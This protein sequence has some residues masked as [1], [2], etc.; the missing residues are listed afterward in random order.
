MDR[1]IVLWV[2]AI[3]SIL[4]FLVTVATIYFG[5]QTTQLQSKVSPCVGSAQV[6]ESKACQEYRADIARSGD[7]RVAC[8]NYE[9]ATGRE[10]GRCLNVNTGVSIP[11]SRAEVQAASHELQHQGGGS[12]QTSVPSSPQQPGPPQGGSDGSTGETGGSGGEQ[13]PD[14]TP[15][16]GPPP[17]A[18]EPP[19][20]I[21]NVDPAAECQVN[22]LG[23]RVCIPQ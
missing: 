4:L 8:I 23:I 20:P 10:P 22:A 6:Q 15:Q 1:R 14:N 7:N 11:D 17:T 2:T 9:R 19:A 16:P 21:L 5:A 3:N 12:P 13:P 18:P